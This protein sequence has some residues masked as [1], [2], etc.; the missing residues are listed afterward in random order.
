M[1][2]LQRLALN[3]IS[4]KISRTNV[5]IWAGLRHSVPSY[6]KTTNCTSSTTPLSFRIDNKVFDAMKKKSKDYYL[7]IKRR[8]A[9]LPNNSRF[10]K[11]DFNLIDDQLKEVFILP[12]NLAFEPYVKAF[13]YKILN[14]ILYTNSKLYKIGYTAV[15]KCS[16]CELEPETLP[17][18]F[19]HFVLLETVRILL[20]FFD[21]RIRSL[22]FARHIDRNNNL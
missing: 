4:Q 16:F 17:H 22:Y 21:K 12:H 20:L 9:Q 18:L 5:L 11:H 7:L 15:D 14:S 6:L 3:I 2:I 1:R 19:F 8:K 10:L 13:Q